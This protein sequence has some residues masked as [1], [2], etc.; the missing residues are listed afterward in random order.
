MELRDV[1][2]MALLGGL[3]LL[4]EKIINMSGQMM[5]EKQMEKTEAVIDMVDMLFRKINE[6]DGIE[7]R[8]A[9]K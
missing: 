3:L 7:I 8:E 5:D 1:E 9:I 6:A 2:K 4:Q